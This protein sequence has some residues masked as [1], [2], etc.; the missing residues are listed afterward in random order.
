[1][2]QCRNP[3]CMPLIISEELAFTVNC[4]CIVVDNGVSKLRTNEIIVL[5]NELVEEIKV[6]L[7]VEILSLVTVVKEIT[8]SYIV[9]AI[10]E[11]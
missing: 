1:M 5:L 11:P 2:C 7:V 4:D 6:V 3:K 10:V 9:T 8:S